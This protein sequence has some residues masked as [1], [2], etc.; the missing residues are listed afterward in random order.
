M[1]LTVG[2]WVDLGDGRIA[3]ISAWDEEAGTAIGELPTGGVIERPIAFAVT[4]WRETPQDG[5]RVATAIDPPRVQKLAE[6]APIDVVI[7]ALTDLG[8]RGQTHEIR[9]LIS[10]SLIPDAEWERWWRRTQ[11]KLEDDER[12][13]TSRTRDKVYVLRG[14]LGSRLGRSLLPAIRGDTRRGRKMAD[15][16]QLRRARERALRKG[17]RNPDD[18]PL[19]DIELELAQD[20]SVDPTDRFM[21][22]ELG[23]WL[24]RWPEDQAKEFLGDDILA[25][26]LLHIPQHESKMRALEWAIERAAASEPVV[27]PLAF[28]SAAAASSPWWDRTVDAL[29]RDGLAIRSAA[30]GILGWSIP[31]DEDAGPPSLKDD[32]PT[33]ERR[34]ERAEQLVPTLS[35]DAGLGLWDGAIHAL[36]TFPDSQSAY[37]SEV[38]RIAE[39]IARMS[40]SA[41]AAIDG[42]RRPKLRSLEPMSRDRLAA[43]ARSAPPDAIRSIRDVVVAWYATDPAANIASL[44]VIAE[45]AREDVRTLGLEA[46]SLVTRKTTLP[47]IANQLFREVVDANAMDEVAARV[48]NLAVTTIED[49]PTV[50]RAL[51][52]LAEAAAE[53]YLRGSAQP[54]GPITFSRSGWERFGRLISDRV[55]EATSREIAAQKLAADAQAEAERMRALAEAR[56]QSLTEART[57][58]ESGTRQDAG[59]LASNLLKPVA[60]AVGDSFESNSLE[61]LQDRLLAVLQ[62]ARIVPI[63][64][65]GDEAPF[66]PARHQWVGE[67]VPTDRVQARSPGFVIEGEGAH[68]IV[69]VPARVV[70]AKGA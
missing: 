51:D 14:P 37:P 68:G 57:T 48:V 62:R 42:D 63:H 70:A 34:I 38:V 36:R 17:P 20:P 52:R 69:L 44:R 41:F 46:A 26:D 11:V 1:A 43:L 22:A 55:E 7:L 30:F 35:V 45:V 39:R 32:I 21:A 18:Q 5:L 29:G 2:T 28:R 9:A 15:G 19:F 16:P 24:D 47:R 33:F 50:A 10:P 25:V 12:I 61:S 13:D 59:R 3:L 58:A 8:G 49:D 4:R 60:L 53:A 6:D 66:D 67:G 27:A 23:A 64:E 40:W 65:V 56:A 31:G 54:M